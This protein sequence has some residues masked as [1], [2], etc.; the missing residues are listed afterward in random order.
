[1]RDKINTVP[2]LKEAEIEDFNK[3]LAAQYPRYRLTLNSFNRQNFFDNILAAPER[4]Q[5]LFNK[6][7]NYTQSELKFLCGLI[8]DCLNPDPN[9]RTFGSAGRLRFRVFCSIHGR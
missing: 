6:K 8:R 3:R 5:D 2:V 4:F 1:M 9:A 7:G